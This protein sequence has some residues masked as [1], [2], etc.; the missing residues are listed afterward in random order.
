MGV[1]ESLG[2][3]VQGRGKI[4][5]FV[6]CSFPTRVSQRSGSSKASWSGWWSHVEG[7]DITGW[8][9][10]SF[11]FLMDMFLTGSF[12]LKILE[13]G[14]PNIKYLLVISLL[15]N[16]LWGPGANPTSKLSGQ[17]NTAPGHK[18]Q[19]QQ[20]ARATKLLTKVYREERKIKI[21]TPGLNKDRATGTLAPDTRTSRGEA[22]EQIRGLVEDGATGTIAPETA[23][24]LGAAQHEFTD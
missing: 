19:E 14:R 22:Q 3:V 5:W 7:R 24:Q 8:G 15:T 21:T 17:N 6:G 18:Y 12:H 4:W 9:S 20:P 11:N 1:L 2:K 23:T 10:A 16:R 13:L